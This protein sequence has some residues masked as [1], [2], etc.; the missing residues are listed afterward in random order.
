MEA[1]DLNVS[2]VRAENSVGAVSD[3]LQEFV[4]E[5]RYAGTAV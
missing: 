1:H 5:S 4:L 2:G 3:I